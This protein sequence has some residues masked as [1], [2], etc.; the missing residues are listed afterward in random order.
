MELD[1]FI[2]ITVSHKIFGKGT[3]QNAEHSGDNILLDIDFANRN[4]L[5]VFPDCINKFIFTDNEQILAFAEVLRKEILNKNSTLD[6]NSTKTIKKPPCKSQNNLKIK[7]PKGG[8]YRWYEY[9]Y[10]THVILQTEKFMYSAHRKSAEVL[11]AVM[12][13]E[14]VYGIYDGEA[15]T[16]GPDL[17][18]I[19]NRFQYLNLSYI[20]ISN[21]QI[22]DKFD[23]KNPFI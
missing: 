8:W 4:A 7:A 23:G 16:G 5:F 3:I 15:Y 1:Q 10:P 13:Y 22:E 2:G 6:T 19:A 17:S 9:H 14:V 21:G 18:I 11:G 20:A 12:N